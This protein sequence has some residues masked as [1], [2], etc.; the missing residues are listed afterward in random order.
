MQEAVYHIRNVIVGYRRT[1]VIERISIRLH[2][3]KPYLV[4][5]TTVGLAEHKN[6]GR[7]SGVWLEHATRHGNDG[8]Q[9]L[10]VNYLLADSHVSPG[11]SEEHS[12]RHDAGAA[13]A[14]LQGADKL[15]EEQQLGLA[16]VGVGK[17][18][19]VHI[20]LVETARKRRVRHDERIAALVFVLLRERIAPG[21]FRGSNVVQQ[22]VHGS[23]AQHG[24]VGIV[25]IDHRGF[26]VMNILAYIGSRLIV[27]LNIFNSLNEES[28]RTHGWVA[29]VIFRS[30]LHHLHNHSDDV[31]GRAELSV[32]AACRHLAENVFIYIA[33]RI[34][35]VHVERIHAIY[36]LGKGSGVGNEED[37]RLHVAAVGAFFACADVLDEFEHV[38]S[39]HL[40]HIVSAQVFEH[41]PAQA[42]VRDSSLL[43]VG[44]S[45]GVN[46]ELSFGEGRVFHLAIPVACVLFFLQLLVVEHFHE[47]DVG[48]LFQHGDRVCNASHKECVPYLVYLVFD[49][50][51]YHIIIY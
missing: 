5:S 47:E 41:V 42:F 27:L 13:A 4:R 33:H 28:G 11:S 36:H 38:L 23:Y 10:V 21:K 46:P 49:F 2:V 16:G 19:L 15:S 12:I 32:G 25:A 34:A 9:L 39:Y 6:G 37:S 44:G 26:H 8:T 3:V 20:A 22:Q 43:L 50:S 29:D 18:L 7:N 51:C 1:L 24:L 14:Q 17:N 31:S 48:H 40:E 45:V 30:R 35:V